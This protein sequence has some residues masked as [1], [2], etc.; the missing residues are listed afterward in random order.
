MRGAAYSIA[1]FAAFMTVTPS[2]WAQCP[3]GSGAPPLTI[4]VQVVPTP[5]VFGQS[6]AVQVTTTG[7]PACGPAIGVVQLVVDNTSYGDTFL[8]AIFLD[9]NGNATINIPDPTH[10]IPSPTIVFPS[11]G[12]HSVGV[13]YGS[14][15]DCGGIRFGGGL[16]PRTCAFSNYQIQSSSSNAVNT[17]VNKANTAT[18]VSANTN[19]TS[20]TAFVSAASPGSGNPTGTV[21]FSNFGTT[22]GTA[23][24]SGGQATLT[25]TGV[26]GLIT[27]S[28]SG[29]SDFLSSASLPLRVGPSPTSVLSLASSLNPSTIGQSVT[30][31]ATLTVANGNGAP[32]GTV[33]FADSATLLGTPVTLSGGQATFTTSSLTV[34]SHALNATYSGDFQYPSTGVS[35]GQSV[36]RVATTVSVASSPSAPLSTQP[37]TLTVQIGPAPPTGVPSPTGQVTFNEGTN[38]LG[39]ATVSA[40]TATGV[41]GPLTPGTHQIAAVYSGDADWSSKTSTIS[42]T[43]AGGPLTINTQTLPSG[44]SGL[45]YPTTPVMASGGTPPYKFS[46]TLPANL[47][48][49]PSS[50]AISGTP[51]AAGSFTVTIQVSDAQGAQVSKQFTLQVAPGPLT[52][53]TQTLPGGTAGS[54][55]SAT[56]AAAGGTPPYTFSATL[57]GGLTI[58]PASG[59]ISGTTSVTGAVTIT[60]NVKDSA[61][62]PVTASKT[63]TVNFAQPTVPPL[64]PVTVN[65]GTNAGPNAQPAIQVNLGAP[66]PSNITGTLKLTFQADIGGDNPEVQFAAG[67]RTLTFTIPAGLTALSP[68]PQLQTGTVAGLI[69]ISTQITSPIAQAGPTEQIPVN[70]A[71]P[72]ILSVTA[73]RTSTGFTVTVTGFSTTLDMTQAN[74]QFN[75]ASGANLQTTSIAI[76]LG[77]LFSSFYQGNIPPKPTGSQ[78]A[79]TQPF[80]VTGSGSITSVTVTMSNSSGAS[81]AGTAT[82]Q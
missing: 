37:I 35:I 24:L 82:I 53:T 19:G 46:G 63:Y 79:Y 76:P 14:G 81:Q 75:A 74:F 77:S 52:I 10:A 2:L 61:S 67:G 34:G 66:Y 57:P 32:T 8:N 11:P 47:A 25:T 23:A 41:I 29:D 40:A 17:T 1:T 15:G 58:D 4:N 59:A 22:I 21:S 50:G 31:T 20:F 18:A 68:S 30:F 80:T 43:V 26:L 44:T 62:T 71:P 78:F 12:S 64:P 42:I 16:A 55:Y 65:V 48:I 6:V 7:T 33:Q 36:N 69:T 49:D 9:S 28:Y 27:A 70:V 38:Q 73:S 39:V 72:T 13:V 60:V 45:P 54:P 51:K 5:S 3:V 56:V